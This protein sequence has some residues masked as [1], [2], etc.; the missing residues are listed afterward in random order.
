MRVFDCFPYFN[1]VE[2]LELRIRLLKDHVSGF[3]I[4]EGDHT[5]SGEPKPFTCVDQLRDRGLL[6]DSV[7]VI[8]VHMPSAQEL[9]NPWYRER[10]Q[11]D[12]ASNLFEPDAVYIVSD[13]DEIINPHMIP[14]FVQGAQQN[15]NNILRIHMAWLMGRA[16]L[17]VCSPERQDTPFRH[18]FVCQSHHVNQFS[19]SMIREDQACELHKLP[20]GS[21]YLQDANGAPVEAGWH[22]SWMGDSARRRLKMQACAHCDDAQTGIFQ[23][24][25]GAINSAEMH[26]YLAS[27]VP[28]VDSQDAYGRSDYFLKSYDTHQLPAAIFQHSNLKDFFLGNSP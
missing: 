21:I 16:D 22:M 11:R 1:E 18:A 19:L 3:I 14:T 2:T 6:W 28:D 10:M 5:H 7:N 15:P 9:P 17:R 23:T 27:Y 12:L 4:T 8:H 13:C 25:V 20:F 24:A 26:T